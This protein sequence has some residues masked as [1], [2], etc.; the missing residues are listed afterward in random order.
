VSDSGLNFTP[1]ENKKTFSQSED[2]VVFQKGKVIKSK[3]MSLPIFMNTISQFGVDAAKTVILQELLKMTE[4]EI[5]TE[6]NILATVSEENLDIKRSLRAAKFMAIQWMEDEKRSQD[7]RDKCS[8]IIDSIPTFK[9]N[10]EKS[11]GKELPKKQITPSQIQNT[12]PV[13]SNT[14]EDTDGFNILE[15]PLLKTKPSPPN[16]PVELEFVSKA[17]TINKFLRGER[18]FVITDIQGDY[19]R[20]KD[21]LLRHRLV[22]NQNGKLVWNKDTKSK[23]VI[24]GDLFNKSPYSNWGGTVAMQT[25]PVIE[26]IRRLVTESDN[27]IFLSMGNYDVQLCSG[28]IFNDLKYGFNSEISGIKV[29]AQTLPFIISYIENT[30]YDE[31][32]NVY[33]LWEKD[34]NTEDGLFFK[35]KPEFQ[36][37][38]SPDIR[39][40]ANELQLPDIN[41][42]RYFLQALYNELILSKTE[43]PKTIK[44][45]DKR[46]KNFFRQKPGEKLESLT[47]SKERANLFQGILKGSKTTD[48]LKKFISSTNKF[49]TEKRENLTFSHVS[50]KNDYGQMLEKAKEL[51]WDISEDLHKTLADSKFLKMKR[52]DTKKL[53]NDLNKVGFNNIQEFLTKDPDLF[54]EELTANHQL[55]LF[56]PV[57][58]PNKLK[59]GYVKGIERFQESIKNED[60]TG[61]LGYKLINRNFGNDFDDIEMKKVSDLNINAKNAYAEKVLNDIFGSSKGFIIKASEDK[62]IVCDR[63]NTK[64][65]IEIDKT[66]ALYQDENKNIQVPIKHVVMISSN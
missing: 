38:G 22:I 66:A 18:I 64:V 52:V 24:L 55:D 62:Q 63:L 28:Q 4:H 30:S 40:K 48:F 35:L 60:R 36:T 27:N 34:T 25:F 19:N 46:V 53:A 47:I 13:M 58:S 61:V 29:Q 5:V 45:L 37:N 7:I 42:V 6:L 15:N 44:E 2:D 59:F 51:N 57:I 11:E 50:F 32:S 3:V 20:L 17:T 16:N 39:I 23:L 21:N 12:M 65:V 41:S 31:Y 9:V 10:K 8:F 43:R 56:I 26:L 33:S 49:Q 1:S 14:S 54:F